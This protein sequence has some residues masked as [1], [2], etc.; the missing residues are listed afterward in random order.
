LMKNCGWA[1]DIVPRQKIR[2]APNVFS[3]AFAKS[4]S[5]YFSRFTEPRLIN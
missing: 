3:R 2:N 5:N 4:A 1:G